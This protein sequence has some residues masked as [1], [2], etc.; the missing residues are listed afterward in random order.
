MVTSSNFVLVAKYQLA[1][2]DVNAHPFDVV[3]YQHK[4]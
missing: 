4:V 1:I 3:S 2:L